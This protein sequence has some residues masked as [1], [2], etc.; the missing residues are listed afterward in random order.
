MADIAFYIG[1]NR[2]PVTVE[3]AIKI[4]ADKLA[5]KANCQA[6]FFGIGNAREQ[7]R[8]NGIV[9]DDNGELAKRLI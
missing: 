4:Q 6:V 5:S 9:G 7:G 3:R 1:K 2:R 8:Q